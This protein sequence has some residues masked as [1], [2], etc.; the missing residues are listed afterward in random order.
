VNAK[1]KA[2]YSKPY[3]AKHYLRL[4]VPEHQF[5]WYKNIG[6]Y[7]R[8]VY[9]APRDHGKTTVIP[10]VITEH[11][12]LY[13]KGFNTLLLSKTFNQANKTLDVIEAD[14]TKNPYIQKDFADELQDF[15]RKGNQLFYNLGENVR[16]DATVEAT[17]ILGDVTGGHFKRIIM[18]DIFDDENTRTADGRRKIMKFIEG[19]IL[20]LLEPNC[21]LLGIG[22]RKHWDDG[23]QK[24]IDNPA[25]YVS[26]EQAILKWPKS[27]EYVR[28]ENG[29]IIDV[30]N[31]EGPYKTLWPQKWG[32]KELLLQAK[33]MGIVLFNREYQNNAEGMKG[34]I[35]KEEWIQHYAIKEENQTENVKG[36]P[37]LEA[38]EI[39]QGVDLAIKKG[40]KNDFFCCET[41]GITRQP[42][43]IWILDW[44]H[45]KISFPSQVKQLKKLYDGPLT[46]IWDGQRWNVLRIGIESNAYQVAL[47]QQLLDEANYPIEEITSIKD[48][49]VR[50][51]AG[52]NDY[53]NGLIMVPVDHPKYPTFL[54]EY[55]SFDEGEH[56]D[57]LDSDDIVRRLILKRPEENF[58]VGVL[59]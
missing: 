59:G 21:G 6:N 24:M 56:D 39:Y 2:K 16:R 33:A 38:M 54:N 18:D 10:R 13:E 11:E 32:I 3:Y 58:T 53:E 1:T 29:I 17:G 50:I 20:P 46:P 5:K 41:I 49:K 35:F 44:Y 23:Y 34:S 8:E 4:N 48:K 25:W 14:L 55:V 52:S 45:D 26:V 15:R 43:K 19:T 27:Y 40:E 22:T 30:V 31:I 51:T 42:F 47:A 28:D 37:P 9:L 36:H 12:T 57:I 7:L